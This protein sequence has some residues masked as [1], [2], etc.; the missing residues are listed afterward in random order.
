MPLDQETPDTAPSEERR[1]TRAL[2]EE[3]RAQAIELFKHGIGYTKASRIL[4]ISVNTVRDWSRGFKKG[5]FKAK[6][7]ENQYR[8]PQSVR[9]NVIRMRLSGFSWSEIYKRSGISSST[10][11][12]WVDDYCCSKGRRKQLLVVPEVKPKEP[13]VR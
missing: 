2:S 12:K 8:Y 11:R 1:E 6:I 3:K 4:N 7:S 10:A 13:S 9:E 5:T